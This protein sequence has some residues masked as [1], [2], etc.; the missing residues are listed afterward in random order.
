MVSKYPGGLGTTGE[1]AKLRGKGGFQRESRE[2]RRIGFCSW[3]S[4]V[5]GEEI[6]RHAAAISVAP[7]WNPITSG[8]L[9]KADPM[10]VVS[11]NVP[12]CQRRSVSPAWGAR[13]RAP[14]C[15]P[16]PH[17]SSYFVFP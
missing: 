8:G 12:A 7:S 17:F 4:L 5:S 2:L 11:S 3:I 1:F 13:P 15:S 10:F 9:S 6:H 14:V 16:S